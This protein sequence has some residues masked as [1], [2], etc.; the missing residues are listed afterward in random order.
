[1][2]QVENSETEHVEN[3]GNS[4]RAMWIMAAA[5]LFL[6]VV[7]GAAMIFSSAGKKNKD[8]NKSDGWV[9]ENEN[10]LDL[11]SSS[12]FD[13]PDN[14]FDGIYGE[15][16]VPEGEGSLSLD[17]LKGENSSGKE[18]SS[19]EVAEKVDTN[20]AE[21]IEATID[22][23]SIAP[24]SSSV[25]AKNDFTAAQIETARE[26]ARTTS[27]SSSSSKSSTTSSSSSTKTS[28]KT[29]STSSSKS[30][31]DKFW[32][33]VGSFEDINKANSARATLSKNG[34]PA[35]VF[36]YE[37]GGRMMYRVR[38]GSYSTKSEAE[39]VREKVSSINPSDFGQSFV[40]NSTA[41]R[42]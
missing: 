32:V 23:S 14:P 30:L 26:T 31:S 11:N 6:L 27:S 39:K 16:G 38:V 8:E 1:M 24:T 9:H 29:T 5:G 19:T 13:A 20:E 34:L 15:N 40:V 28:S 35:E 2:S 7:V 37:D 17:D 36:T 25:V 12:D 33:Q 41:K 42:L 22:L 4:K 18:D 21:K 10:A 3:E